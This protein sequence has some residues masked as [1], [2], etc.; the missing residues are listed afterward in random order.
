MTEKQ[1]VKKTK[2]QL[3]QCKYVI[4]QEVGEFQYSIEVC[5]TPAV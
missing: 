3:Q 5:S 4:S 2:K 1:E